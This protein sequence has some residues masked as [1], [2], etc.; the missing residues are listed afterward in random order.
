MNYTLSSVFSYNVLW[1]NLF[2]IYLFKKY[3]F[4]E[5]Q[6]ADR[7]DRTD[8]GCCIHRHSRTQVQKYVVIRRAN[9]FQAAKD[10]N[11]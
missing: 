3:S 5:N 1:H 8:G 11:G 9:L 7:Y 4:L 2:A 6:D 10:E